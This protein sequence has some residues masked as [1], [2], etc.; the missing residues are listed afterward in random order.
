MRN[1]VLPGI[2][3]LMDESAFKHSA[4]KIAHA[5][6]HVPKPKPPKKE[7]KKSPPPPKPPKTYGFGITEPA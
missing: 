4:E 3:K 6:P 7:E 2:K 1:K 5:H